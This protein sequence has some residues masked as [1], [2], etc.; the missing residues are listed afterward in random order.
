MFLSNEVLVQGVQFVRCRARM[1]AIKSDDF[2]SRA[3]IREISHSPV[4]GSGFTVDEVTVTFDPNSGEKG[5]TAIAA[6]TGSNSG[7]SKY[8]KRSKKCN[9][10]TYFRCDKCDMSA[11][12][13]QKGR[14]SAQNGY[15]IDRNN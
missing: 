4:E 10:K 12:E 13:T 5:Y 9:M 8:S 11:Q 14:H 1:C 6:L 7:H 2:R 3:F 15:K